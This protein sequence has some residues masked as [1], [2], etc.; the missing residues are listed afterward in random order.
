MEDIGS[1]ARRLLEKLDARIAGKKAAG[2]LKG[3]HEFDAGGFDSWSAPDQSVIPTT[4]PQSSENVASRFTVR[5]GR[6]ARWMFGTR[7]PQA[8][9]EGAGPRSRYGSLATQARRCGA[10]DNRRDHART[11]QGSV[12][13]TRHGDHASTG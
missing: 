13:G 1:A 12:V 3:R 6:N 10:N 4:R 5:C 7:L 9:G 11:F 8:H 2:C